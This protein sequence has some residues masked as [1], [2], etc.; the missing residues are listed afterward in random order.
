M[1]K[2]TSNPLNCV[3]YVLFIFQDNVPML[4]TSHRENMYREHEELC[5][6][7]QSREQA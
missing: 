2:S 6:K 4:P 5:L 3:E 1:I 7:E